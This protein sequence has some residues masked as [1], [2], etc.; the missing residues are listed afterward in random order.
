MEP[1]GHL[2]IRIL[3]IGL[4]PGEHQS[5][6]YA[7]VAMTG[8]IFSIKIFVLVMVWELLVGRFTRGFTIGCMFSNVSPHSGNQTGPTVT[9]FCSCSHHLLAI[10]GPV[11][12]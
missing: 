3:D 10:T 7:I 2:K 9:P 1:T 5:N 8:A 6:S 11:V 12:R 4:V